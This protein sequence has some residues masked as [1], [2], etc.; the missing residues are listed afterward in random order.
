MESATDFFTQK[1][2]NNVLWI[3]L[4]SNW[5]SCRTIQGVIVL[6]ISNQTRVSRSS[7]PYFYNNFASKMYK[8][9]RER[10]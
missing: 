2:F 3:R 5:T 6:L 1:T 7:D 10:T 8:Y 4:I 9:L